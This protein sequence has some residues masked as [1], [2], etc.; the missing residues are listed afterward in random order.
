M[1]LKSYAQFEILMNIF[2][3]KSPRIFS[4]EN[5]RLNHLWIFYSRIKCSSKSRFARSQNKKKGSKMKMRETTSCEHARAVKFKFQMA[6]N[7]DILPRVNPHCCTRRSPTKKKKKN[8]TGSGSARGNQ[9]S[10]RALGARRK[11]GGAKLLV[12]EF[13]KLCEPSTGHKDVKT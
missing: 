1:Y 11:K 3:N 9:F 13:F 6:N 10:G 5:S 12:A 8:F 4:R 2:K 7:C